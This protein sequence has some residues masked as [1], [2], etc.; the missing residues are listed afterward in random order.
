M[1]G[2]KKPSDSAT[3]GAEESKRDESSAVATASEQAEVAKK[4]AVASKQNSSFSSNTS[5]A[6]VNPEEVNGY[7]SV[8]FI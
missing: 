2:A 5:N 1:T 7:E 6:D 8:C 3:G 4:Q